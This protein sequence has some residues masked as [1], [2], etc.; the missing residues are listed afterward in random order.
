MLV[1]F[2]ITKLFV[3][4][5]L[6]SPGSV[7]LHRKLHQSF[8]LLSPAFTLGYSC[9]G[10]RFSVVFCGLFTGQICHAFEFDSKS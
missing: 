8:A 2:S 10:V 1:S 3:F 5:T 9:F 7:V 6:L 4:F